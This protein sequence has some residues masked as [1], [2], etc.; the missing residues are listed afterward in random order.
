M[1]KII[2]LSLISIVFSCCVFSP[3]SEEEKKTA[4]TKAAQ[5]RI[6]ATQRSAG[7][8]VIPNDTDIE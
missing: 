8:I 7:S 4:R 6:D 2:S 1:K 5:E 3:L